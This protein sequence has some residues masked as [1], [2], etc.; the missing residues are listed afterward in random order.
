MTDFALADAKIRQLYARY[1]DAVWRKDP[2]AFGDC[3]TEDVEWRIAGQVLHGRAAAV[4]M[5]KRVLP[6]FRW[7]SINFKTPIITVSDG[8]ATGRCFFME[9]SVFEHGRTF[10][11][12]GTYYDHYVDQGDCWRFSWRL[13]QTH[14]AGSPDLS[15]PLFENPDFG[16]PPNMPPRDAPT[17]NHSSTVIR[18]IAEA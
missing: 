3:L 12:M 8:K 18:P 10:A 6:Q 4:E 7:C 17:F 13:F 14:Y 5:I 16:P 1:A 11:A 15:G 2:E 9:Q